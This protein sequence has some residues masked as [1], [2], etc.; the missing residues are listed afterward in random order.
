MLIVPG[1]AGAQETARPQ[2]PK[3]APTPVQHAVT[4]DRYSLSI[5]GQRTYIWSGSFQYWRLPSPGLWRDVLQKM[6]SAGFNAVTLYFYWGYHSPRDGVYDFSGVRDVDKL[7]DMAQ[8]A[9]LYVIARPGP[10]IEAESN[11]G[12]LPGWLTGIKGISRSTAPD[13]TAAYMQWMTHIDAII[14][15]HQITDGTGP[16]ILYQPENEFYDGSQA[17]RAYMQA[18]ENKARADGITVPFLG[19]NDG[20]FADGVGAVELPGYDSY[21]QGFDCSHPDHRNPARDFSKQRAQ[22]RRS[23]LYFPE[24]QGGSFDPWGGPGYAAC[25]TLTGP[26]FERVFYE[27]NIAQGS[28]MQNFYMTFGGTSWGWL[29]YPGVYTSYDYG[30]ALN[31]SRQLTPKYYQQK[32]LGYFVAAVKPLTQT[33][34]LAVRQPTDRS[35]RLDGRVN[36][37]NGTR[38]YVLRHANATSG[39]TATTHVWL[40]LPGA[41]GK[42]PRQVLVPQQAGTSIRIH[43]RDSKLLLANYRFGHQ[44]LVYSTSQLMTDV[45]GAGGDTL[46]LY[47]PKGEAGETVLAYPSQPR[48]DV[49][50]GKAAT[51][52]DAA[53]GCLRLDY[54]HAG[55]AR[56]RIADAG[57]DLLLLIGTTH[58]LD[59]LWRL[60]TASGAVLVNGPHLV[61]AAVLGA[62]GTLQL[63]GDTDRPTAVEVFAPAATK[64]VTWNDVDVALTR[65]AS[66]SL[67]GKLAGPMPL[68][69]PPLTQWKFKAGAPE[70]ALRFN[71]AKWIRASRT[72]SN[73]P[74]LKAGQPVLDEDAYG[75]HNGDVWYRGHF[76][77]TGKEKGIILT[78]G[79]GAHGV[80]TAWLNGHYLGRG[81]S[82]RYIDNTQYFN[83]DPADLAAGKDNVVSVLVANMGHEENDDSNK[84]FQQ[85]RGLISASWAGASTPVAWRVQGNRGGETPIDPV[86]GIYN[87]GGL[88]GERMGWSLP[89][90]PD[91][92]WRGVTLPNAVNRPGVDWYRTTFKLDIPADQDVPI[93]LK[94]DDSPSRHYRALIFINGWQFGRYDNALGPQRAFVLPPGLLNPHGD[95]TIAIA[96]WS[97]EHS[98][99]LGKVS[100][101]E[102][103][104]ER[105]SL[106]VKMVQAPEYDEAVYAQE[107]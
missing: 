20:T 103:G 95:N 51:H 99:G 56:V 61:R 60:D 6:K 10:Y 12:G 22:N 21:P 52:W 48:V 43:G 16:V 35:L 30:A 44:D 58:E 38:I 94:I 9:G 82:G 107:H 29:A 100:L 106:R 70:I 101:V 62:D 8:Q 1:I 93:A 36:P 66:G 72:S 24:F 39:T 31:E 90:Y 47:N 57:H 77:A 69:L 4:Y 33:D 74:F 59:N 23:P 2:V 91:A 89:G 83:I 105:T 45:A 80:F 75:F 65:T 37:V 97:T 85:P 76:K 63:T 14:A 104:S 18:I 5:N 73:N 54:V 19:N 71:D 68:T 40:S 25:R 78:A 64:A 17:G 11:A 87:N 3:I 84:A 34:R 42:P 88:Y 46:V 86:R 98:G 26:D 41:D 13:Y 81:A 27:S 92:K 67:E 55:L 7:L 28:T 15:K 102:L 49:L 96:S 50:A 79:T 53:T 32:L